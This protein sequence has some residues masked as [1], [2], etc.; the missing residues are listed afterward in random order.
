VGDVI[1]FGTVTRW[2]QSGLLVR[3]GDQ[4]VCAILLSR[5]HGK[6]QATVALA[7]PARHLLWLD[8]VEMELPAVP[9]ARLEIDGFLLDRERCF[10]ATLEAVGDDRSLGAALVGQATVALYTGRMGDAAM[11]VS[12]AAP[13]IWYGNRLEEGDYDNL[14]AVAGE[15]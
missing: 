9:P 13:R 3:D 15:G 12:G 1:Q 10:P 7:P 11:V 14:G 5:E 4:L 6:E 2:P 8:S